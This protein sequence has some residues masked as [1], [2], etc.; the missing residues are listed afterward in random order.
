MIALYK[1][2]RWLSDVFARSNTLREERASIIGGEIR[3]VAES[4]LL[5]GSS[6]QSQRQM[7]RKCY[8]MFEKDGSK[9]G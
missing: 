6:Q 1:R 3:A 9:E 4:R 8:M 2:E 7:N 5:G